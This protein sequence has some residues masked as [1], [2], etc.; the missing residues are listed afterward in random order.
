MMASIAARIFATLAEACN[1]LEEVSLDQKGPI[2]L[3]TLLAHAV[4]R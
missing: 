2:L 4:R 1:A 3:E